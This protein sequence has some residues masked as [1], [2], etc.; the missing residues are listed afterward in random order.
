MALPS[1]PDERDF[2]NQE[3]YQEAKGYY[4]SHVGR[5]RGLVKQAATSQG[6]PLPSPSTEKT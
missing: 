1:P 5:M 3:E 6:Y 4:S 2:H